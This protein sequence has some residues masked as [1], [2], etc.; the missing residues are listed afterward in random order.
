MS[1]AFAFVCDPFFFRCVLRDEADF[2]NTCVTFYGSFSNWFC[3]I[4]SNTFYFK[5]FVSVI[6]IVVCILLIFSL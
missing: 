1:G 4:K 3:S 6:V 5:I 2:V